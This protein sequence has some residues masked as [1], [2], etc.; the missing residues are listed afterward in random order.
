MS[1]DP[2]N[3]LLTKLCDGDLAAGIE[4]AVGVPRPVSGNREKTAGER[5]LEE[6]EPPSGDE[7]AA[8]VREKKSAATSPTIGGRRRCRSKPSAM[9]FECAPK[10]SLTSAPR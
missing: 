2:V 1:A 5:F 6:F 9:T 10:A 3:A 4:L 7:L 8:L